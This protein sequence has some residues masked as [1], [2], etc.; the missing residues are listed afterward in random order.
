[1]SE[2]NLHDVFE[3][4]R[5]A[6]PCVLF[7][8]EIDAI[9]FARRRTWAAPAVRSSTSS[10]RNSTRSAPTTRASSSSRR[11]TRPGTSTKRSSVP[12]GSTARCSFRRPMSR[13]GDE[14][15]ELLVSDRPTEKLD[16]KR[17]ASRTPLF[18]GADLMRWSSGRW[19]RSS[20]RS[21]LRRGAADAEGAL[22]GGA[23]GMRPTTLEWL[24]P[25]G[26]TSSS[27]TRAAATTTCATSS[28]RAKPAPGRNSRALLRVLL[29]GAVGTSAQRRS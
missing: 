16:V 25:R 28:S 7:L 20:T 6:A 8:D 9:G 12:A 1:M 23:Q 17:L 21:R 5:R 13:R 22:R 19:T 4:A 14:S 27:Q 29:R 2:R 11:R 3:Q 18:S 15:F 10:F 24:G 26:T